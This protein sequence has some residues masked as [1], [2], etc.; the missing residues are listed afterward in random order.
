[1]QGPN[2]LSQGR[3]KLGIGSI[4]ASSGSCMGAQLGHPFAGVRCN[5]IECPLVSPWLRSNVASPCEWDMDLTDS[6]RSW[7]STMR[8]C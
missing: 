1:V 8:A 7:S 6:T 5:Q 3:N 2:A 4:L